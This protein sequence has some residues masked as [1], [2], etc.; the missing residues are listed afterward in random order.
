MT[1]HE[2]LKK[3]YNSGTWYKKC[4]YWFRNNTDGTP[5]GRG[6]LIYNTCGKIFYMGD[7]YEWAED[8]IWSC[9]DL[10]MDRKRWP[11]FLGVEKGQRRMTRDPY[12]TFY[13]AIVCHFPNLE[14]L[15]RVKPPWYLITPTFYYWRK[16]LLTGKAKY[17][18]WYYRL[19]IPAKRD[20][21]R[22]LEYYRH[23]AI[24]AI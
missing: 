7:T 11:D 14:D 4:G 17:K 22:R 10:L 19:N 13:A 9:Y 15:I 20:W 1:I 8:A 21:C 23:I 6:D 5:G 12:T 24:Q 18:K 16:Y 2:I 3:F